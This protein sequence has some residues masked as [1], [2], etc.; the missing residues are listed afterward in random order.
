[1]GCLTRRL[2][3]NIVLRFKIFTVIFRRVP[4]SAVFW[5]FHATVFQC[6]C[7]ITWWTLHHMCP[8]FFRPIQCR[9]V[10]KIKS[11]VK[12]AMLKTNKS[13]KKNISNIYGGSIMV[14]QYH[15]NVSF[16]KTITAVCSSLSGSNFG[17]GSDGSYEGPLLSLLLYW[18][19]DSY[20]SHINHYHSLFC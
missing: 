12:K 14:F 15:F 13:S 10:V 9:A 1:M 11:C 19:P 7:V 8:D 17:I 18:R 4:F 2:S 16:F 3:G 20:I 6:F 5:N